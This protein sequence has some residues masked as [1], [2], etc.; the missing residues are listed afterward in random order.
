MGSQIH[1]I[2]SWSVVLVIFGTLLLKSKYGSAAI[3]PEYQT[4]EKVKSIYYRGSIGIGYPEGYS[5]EWGVVINNTE[6]P[7]TRPTKYLKH[8]PSVKYIRRDYSVKRIH[9]F[10]LSGLL[11]SRGNMINFGYGQV[12]DNGLS[13][14]ITSLS[15][16]Q[17]YSGQHYLGFRF[18]FHLFL[19]GTEFGFFIPLNSDMNSSPIG[20]VGL[21]FGI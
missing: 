19:I 6:P 14:S 4:T 15:Y 18:T 17:R 11:G 3:N 2:Y 7:R 16:L 13:T 12:K 1:Y 20:Q 21:R 10:T 5:I 8:N 9:G